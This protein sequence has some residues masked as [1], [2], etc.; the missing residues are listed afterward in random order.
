MYKEKYLKYKIKYIGLKNNLENKNITPFS[1]KILTLNYS[2]FSSYLF[3]KSLA[4]INK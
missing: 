4:C 3:I 2:V 1:L